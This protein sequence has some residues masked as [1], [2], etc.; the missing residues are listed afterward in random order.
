MVITLILVFPDWKK[1][2]HIHVHASY[3]ALGAVL[4]HASEGEMDHP[5][6]FMSRNLSKAKKNYSTTQHEGLAMVYTLHKF[7]HYLL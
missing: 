7:M 1:E 4:T 2:F 6:A 3:I 5:I